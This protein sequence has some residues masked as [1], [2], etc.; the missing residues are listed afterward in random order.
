M[1]RSLEYRKRLALL[2]VTHPY[3]KI[4]RDIHF[5]NMKSIEIRKYGSLIGLGIDN[6]LKNFK[7][8]K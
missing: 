8:K 2:K 3:E 4:H 1:N 6:K 5:K 7:W